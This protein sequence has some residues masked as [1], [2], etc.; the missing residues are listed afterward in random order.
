[1]NFEALDWARLDRLRGKF[2]NEAF[3]ASAY[4]Q[5][6]T[7]LELYDQ[8]FGERIGWKWDAVLAELTR[9]GWSPPPASELW[10]WGCGSGV[11]GRRVLAQWPHQFSTMRVTD[12]SPLAAAF[13]ARRVAKFAPDL[14][15]STVPPAPPASSRPLVLC[16]SHVWNELTVDGREQLLQLASEATAVLWVEPGTHGTARALQQVRAEL[17]VRGGHVVAPCTHASACGL[18]APGNERHWCHHF[19]EPPA[20]VF[21]DSDWV[22]FSHRAGIDLRSLPYAF[23]AFDRRPQ[24]STATH[25]VQ[26]LLGSAR[27]YKGFA[28][29]LFCGA[30]G[31]AEWEVPQR[32]AP[33]VHKAWGKA[34]GGVLYRLDG[35]AGRV[36][37]IEPWPSPDPSESA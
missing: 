22:R 35:K 10:D 4:W 19:A 29:A 28:R 13:A 25:H 31:V 6:E 20:G 17:M 32:S 26:R 3:G 12:L 24:P 7:D 18:L 16:V 2:I 33:A 1:M 27:V 14:L 34:R 5:D 8:T 11:A 36:N 9:R 23:L 30:D 37:Q 15:V 21:A